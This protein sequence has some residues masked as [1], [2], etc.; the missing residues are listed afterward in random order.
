[1]KAEV[2]LSID[3]LGLEAVVTLKGSAGGA[4]ITVESVAALLR[5]KGVKEG[6]VPEA[7]EKAIRALQHKPEEPVR[8]V[9][10]RGVPPH[11][12]E[13]ER[14][15]LE[16]L[17]VPPRLQV[18]A[19]TFLAEAPAPEVYR[20][21]EHRVQKKR[22]VL[23]KPALGFLRPKEVIETVVVKQTVREKVAVDP[24]VQAFGYVRKQAVVARA[25]PAGQGKAGRS[26]FGRPL[27]PPRLPGEELFLGAGLV[28]AGLE[29]RA[30]ASGFLRQ[31]ANWCDL[32]AFQDHEAVVSPAPDKSACFLSYTPGDRRVPA[33]RAGEV[34]EQAV[35]LGVPR[36][37]LLP[38]AEIQR[39]LAEAASGGQPL[40]RVPLVPSSDASISIQVSSDKLKATLSI[41]KGKGAG[42]RLNLQEVSNAI[43]A[44][45]V[46]AFNAEVVKKDL[47][48]FYAGG[49]AELKDYLLAEGR[50]PGTGQEGRLE[51]QVKF[52]K[53]EEAQRV[54]EQ[55]LAAQARL[56]QLKSLADFPLSSVQS[57]A[58]VEA[59]QEIVR[60][61]PA[62]A[63]EPGLDVYKAL[64][65]GIKG[66]GPQLKLFEGLK[67]QK[68]A[69]N[70]AVKGLLERG[71]VG[72]TV[73]LR[74]RP[75]HDAELQVDL[76]EDRMQGLVSFLP[77]EGTG[78][79]FDAEQLKARLVQGGILKGL[80][81]AGFAALAR[82]AAEGKALKDFLVAR[83]RPPKPPPVRQL[84]FH[85]H[86]ASGASVTVSADGRAD[87]RNQDKLTSVRRGELIATLSPPGLG[88]EEGW[89]VSGR[90]VR[91]AQEKQQTLAAGK[92]V[93]SS[94][95]P[96][97]RVQ[98]FADDD[99][100]LFYSENLLEVKRVHLVDGDVDLQRG[101]VRFSGV[102]EVR[103][104]VLSGFTV[105]A[106]DD[107]LVENT[108][109]AATLSAEGAISIR[110]GVKG[111]GKARLSAGRGIRALFAEQA[112][113]RAGGDVRIRNA[114]VRCLLRCNGQL[115]LETEKGNLI[116]GKAQARR[117]LA[118][119]NLG[120]PSGTHT[121]VSFGQDY[122]LLEKIEQAQAESRRLAAKVVEL[123]Q[124]VHQLERPGADHQAL[125]LAVA[126]RHEAQ[127]LVEKAGQGLAALQEQFKRDFPA[128]VVV[129]GVLYPGVVIE[130]HGFTYAPT[131][132]KHLITLRYDPKSRQ[133][134]EK[135]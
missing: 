135:Q 121:E 25:R 12:L 130:S 78:R 52:A 16:P 26:I 8:F 94:P 50:A 24:T 5:A 32:V 65:P 30:E 83:G 67:V 115:T 36:E 29:V 61:F 15:A 19:R 70:A 79:S 42:R 55:S 73:L 80:D 7:A 86:L 98:F 27:P 23:K 47:A 108:V 76:S 77:A 113:L 110:Q 18:F 20:L 38:E 58:W 87:F 91:P 127:S 17:A 62:T 21:S 75:H 51:W 107:L 14:F 82:A 46:R 133:I 69:V 125:A 59:G 41:R 44:S 6:F 3:A 120:S 116:G 34:I 64:I 90:P 99:G 85:V 92:G 33:P 95:L 57:V 40:Q 129:R 72:D 1:M 117:G 48:S 131:V 37:R 54:R 81:P 74:V 123:R 111:E 2:A 71:V 97:G 63:G 128:E 96:D 89:D 101:N 103:G 112:V 4:E 35:R 104:S 22:K 105:E 28:R 13:G 119:Q 106:G 114:C 132:E 134:V 39:L 118:V 49:Q 84:T 53:P 124:R 100:E 126:E 45:G 31:G 11:P 102:V 66:P 88:A 60:A 122:L 9:A 109:Q 43:R 68:D 56:G 93:R 10:A